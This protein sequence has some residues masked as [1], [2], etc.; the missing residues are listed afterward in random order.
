MKRP[1][2]L[3]LSSLEGKY[4]HVEANKAKRRQEALSSWSLCV[5]VKGGG[6]PYGKILSGENKKQ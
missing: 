5:Q 3:E 6:K 4:N 1:S 2:F